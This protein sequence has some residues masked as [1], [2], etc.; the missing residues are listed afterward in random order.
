MKSTAELSTSRLEE[1]RKSF[2]FKKILKEK[3]LNVIKPIDSPK[4]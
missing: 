1:S 3:K 2:N 4:S